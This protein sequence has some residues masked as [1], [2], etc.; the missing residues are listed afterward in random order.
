MPPVAGRSTLSRYPLLRILIPY[1]LGVAAGMGRNALGIPLALMAIALMTI[2]VMARAK[3]PGIV[4]RLRPLWIIPIAMTGFGLGWINVWLAEPLTIDTAALEGKPLVARVDHIAMRDFSM[5]LTATLI[6]T[7]G[8]PSSAIKTEL[9]TRGCDYTLQAGDLVA[10]TAHLRPI[11]N[12]GNPDEMDYV[13]YMHEKGIRYTQHLPA[14]YLVKCGTQPSLMTRLFNLKHRVEHHIL[15]SDLSAPVQHLIIAVILGNNDY[16][17]T[18]TRSRFSQAGIAH[19]LALSGLHVSLIVGII[20]FLLFPL[21]FLRLKK[22]RL[23]ISVVALVVFALF[24]G[25]S[26]SVVRATLMVGLTYIAMVLYRQ[27]PPGNA[28]ALAALVILV[29][30]PL[31]L[32]NVGFQLSFVTVAS[33][34]VF[35][36]PLDFT[37]NKN[38]TVRFFGSILLTSAIASLSTMA[39]TAHYFNMV[40]PMSW[41]ANLVVLPLFTVMMPLC[42]AEVLLCICGVQIGLVERMLEWGYQAIDNIS[43]AITALPASHLGN[44]YISNV[45]LITYFVILACLAL[46][47]HRKRFRYLLLSGA[48]VVALLASM[49]VTRLNTPQQGLLIL[50]NYSCTPI[51]YYN[52]HRAQLW[53]PDDNGTTTVGDL[54]RYHSNLLAHRAIE[55]VDVVVGQT[56]L[57]QGEGFIKPPFCHAMGQRIMC[58]T[59]KSWKRLHDRLDVDWLVMCRQSHYS[60]TEVLEHVQAKTIILSGAIYDKNYEVLK[61]QCATLKH[62]TLHSLRDD[63]AIDVW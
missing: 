22:L 55:Q 48:G 59:N 56:T 52:N 18:D 2:V 58:V 47:L 4:L 21:D 24:T 38:A 46:W 1:A 32:T 23:L 9:T 12:R 62:V 53:I 13:R 7:D 50:N 35:F 3:S 57:G 45:S 19:I 63:G 54:Q 39:L 17:D 33:L 27:S 20:W 6:T 26:P 30:S 16:I 41:L 36:R 49:F 40:S 25:L 51:L 44:I 28:I 8:E 31:S 34:I 29:I 61:Q 37:Q 42:V 11:V 5:K 60:P 43:Q 15:A 14:D 10:F